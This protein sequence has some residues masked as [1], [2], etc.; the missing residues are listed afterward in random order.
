[1]N[2]LLLPN[3][4]PHALAR[5]LSGRHLIGGAMVP[6]T[7]GKTFEVINPATGEV[8]GQAAHGEAP[9]VDAAVAAAEQAQR[10]WGRQPARERGRLVAECGRIL[11]EHVDELG[12][13]VALETG[14]ALR[15]E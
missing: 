2:N 1:M 12:R 4:D 14:K 15:T 10:H 7:S 9:D 6:A 3:L 11:N 8:I 5:E 13:L